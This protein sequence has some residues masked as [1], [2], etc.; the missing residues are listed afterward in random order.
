M[1]RE[2]V[3]MV[4]RYANLQSARMFE[5]SDLRIFLA[6]ARAG[7]TLGASR[8]LGINQSTVGRRIRVLEHQLGLILFDKDT[9]GFHPTPQATALL[10]QAEEM[11]KAAANL[12]IEAGRQHRQSANIIRLTAAQDIF[13]YVLGPI[14]AAF[15]DKHPKLGF[16]FVSD[17]RKL[18]LE[19]GEADIAFRAGDIRDS[20][21]YAHRIALGAFLWT[22]YCSDQYAKSHGL[23][24]GPEGLAGHSI[25]AYEKRIGMSSMS[26]WFMSHVSGDQIVAHCNDVPNMRVALA[27]GQGIGILPCSIADRIPSL[28]R[29]FAPTQQ[30]SSTFSLLVS[31][32]ARDLPLVRSFIKFSAARISAKMPN[33]P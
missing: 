28:V 5:W 23:P 19:K 25:V 29:C 27:T 7:S 33:T 14:I 24:S 17:D 31:P 8:S 4:R 22:A 15:K 9:R 20:D 10:A 21:I 2:Y 13:E 18:N 11:E 12:A 30:M 32:S 6:V 1:R 3:V 26:I 16:E